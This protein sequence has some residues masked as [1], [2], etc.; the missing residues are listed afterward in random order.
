MLEMILIVLAVAIIAPCGDKLKNER[1]RTT[2]QSKTSGLNHF[3]KRI[4]QY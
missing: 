2:R 3:D 4:E 1:T